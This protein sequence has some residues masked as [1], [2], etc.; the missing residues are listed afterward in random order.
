MEQITKPFI[1]HVRSTDKTIQTL[2]NHLLEVSEI[3]KQL[4]AKI[5]APE[6]GELIGLLHD[7]GKYSEQFQDYIKSGTGLLNPDLDYDYVDAKA[8]KGKI[9]HS[10]AGAQWLWHELS[11]Y[12]ENGEGKLC[13]QILALCIVSHHGKGLIDCL[14]P[15]GTNGF[16]KRIKKPDEHT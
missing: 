12:G 5:S 11:K 8:Q 14:Q 4:A 6:A 10:T 15:D 7:F 1:A 13:A 9:D 3:T 16:E 2:A